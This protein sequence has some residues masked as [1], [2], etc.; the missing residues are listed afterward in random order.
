M[1]WERRLQR[2]CARHFNLNMMKYKVAIAYLRSFEADPVL[3]KLSVRAMVEASLVG[4]LTRVRP[5]K[6]SEAPG[7]CSFALSAMEFCGIIF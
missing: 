3:L 6:S 2:R 5:E 4:L 1:G 7:F